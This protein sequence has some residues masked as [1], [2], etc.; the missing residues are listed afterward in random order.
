LRTGG[1]A[2]RHDWAALSG[3]RFAGA[4]LTGAGETGGESGVRPISSAG[5]IGTMSPT[6]PERCGLSGTV[7]RASGTDASGR[8]GFSASPLGTT[9]TLRHFAF[10]QR[11]GLPH[12]VGC[13]W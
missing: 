9:K 2:S 6:A 1:G 3:S 12:S 5:R 4:G 13:T 11:I 10:G 8:R 7:R